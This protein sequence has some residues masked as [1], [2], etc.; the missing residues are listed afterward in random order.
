MGAEEEEEEEGEIGLNIRRENA[1]GRIVAVT[2]L[3]A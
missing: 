3:D 1:H 2:A